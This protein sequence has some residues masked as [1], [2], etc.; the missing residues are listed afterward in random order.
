MIDIRR[1]QLRDLSAIEEIE[2]ERVP[3]A[4]VALDVRRRALEAVVDLPRRLRRTT[5]SSAT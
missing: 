5:C 4:V 3:D 2:R 1:L